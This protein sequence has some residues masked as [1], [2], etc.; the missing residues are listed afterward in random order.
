M[1]ADPSAQGQEQKVL[2]RQSNENS[3]ERVAVAYVNKIT[4]EGRA[5]VT[6]T[7]VNWYLSKANA[8]FGHMPISD[9]T[10]PVVLKALK[11]V[12]KRGH[13]AQCDLDRAAQPCRICAFD[14]DRGK[15]RGF[16]L[17]APSDRR[18]DIPGCPHQEFQDVL[19]LVL[20]C[21]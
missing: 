3:F 17:F 7:K 13:Y 15:G 9:I 6:L 21:G 2:K 10:S 5:E 16:D 1:G 4:K 11:K 8:S 20:P 12:K 18:P 19:H 14:A